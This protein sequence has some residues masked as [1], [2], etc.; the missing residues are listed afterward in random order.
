M[1]IVKKIISIMFTKYKFPEFVFKKIDQNWTDNEGNNLFHYACFHH[2][3]ILFN[4][5]IENKADIQQRNINGLQPIHTYMECGFPEKRL[6]ELENKENRKKKKDLTGLY[7]IK[8]EDKR[9]IDFNLLLLD[10][11]IENGA[12]INSFIKSPKKEGQWGEGVATNSRKNI[13]GSS[14]EIL[15]CLFWDHVL[16]ST[17][18]DEQQIE[19]YKEVYKKLEHYGSN[20]NLISEK[21]IWDKNEIIR[22]AMQEINSVIVSHFFIKYIMNEKDLF[23]IIPIIED[24]NLDFSLADENGN[25]ILHH[26]FSALNRREQSIQKI[27]MQNLLLKVVENPS[28]NE[29]HLQI[30]NGFRLEPTRQFDNRKNDLSQ[31]F[32]K[33]LLKKKLEKNLISKSEKIKRIKI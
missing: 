3:I 6:T 21:T 1:K 12:D 26:L 27:T 16:H 25:T 18:N 30:K 7:T 23:A 28:F 8:S 33:L 15:I 32:R 20:I 11:L 24:K 19:I 29:E 9:T 17:F 2:D 4:K 31:I 5:A 22:D 14:I 10:L 13:R